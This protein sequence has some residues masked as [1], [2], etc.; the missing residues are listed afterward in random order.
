MEIFITFLVF[1][2][3]LPLWKSRFFIWLLSTYVTHLT[4]YKTET[5]LCFDCP[6]L[7]LSRFSN[8]IIK[9]CQC[10]IL[11]LYHLHPLNHSSIYITRRHFLSQHHEIFDHIPQQLSNFTC[12]AYNTHSNS[13][14]VFK[15]LR[16]NIIRILFRIQN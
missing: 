15:I 12:S 5:F 2:K 7:W 6:A 3:I 11:H 16:S 9:H 10:H 13:G 4:I 1:S 14:I 8:I